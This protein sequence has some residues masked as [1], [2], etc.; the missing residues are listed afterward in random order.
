VCVCV[1]VHSAYVCVYIYLCLM[2]EHVDINTP[3]I[4]VFVRN[5]PIW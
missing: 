1:G 5:R 2:H 3:R 4:C